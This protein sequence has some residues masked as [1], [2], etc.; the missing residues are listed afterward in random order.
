[1][2]DNLYP[3]TEVSPEMFRNMGQTARF[4]AGMVKTEGQ[5]LALVQLLL[6]RQQGEGGVRD[7]FN[8]D[9]DPVE[10][11]CTRVFF[12]TG[13]MVESFRRHGQFF[14]LDATC[15]T[16]RFNMPLVLLVGMDDTGSTTM[17]AAA[18]IISESIDSYT[19]VLQCFKKAVGILHTPTPFFFHTNI[20]RLSYHYHDISV[21]V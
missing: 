10:E 18:L 20:M 15:K 4:K 2:F 6:S 16:N 11:T 5:V 8:I 21:L 17:F 12:A 7:Y 19:W 13:G 1:V 9:W 3:G 14:T